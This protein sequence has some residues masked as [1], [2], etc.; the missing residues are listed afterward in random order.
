MSRKVARLQFIFIFAFLLIVLWKHP[1]SLAWEKNSDR[2]KHP[3]WQ[4]I[5][6]SNNKNSS[7]N[8][9]LPLPRI[10]PLPLSL[11]NWK[12]PDNQE[13]YFPQIKPT[14]NGYLIWS[15]FPVRVYLE[16]PPL[17]LANSAENLRQQQWIE[18]VRIAIAEWNQYL[19][20]QEIDNRE[21]ADIVVMPSTPVRKVKINPETGLYD[22]PRAITAQTTYQFYWQENK[23]LSHRMR[24]QV[25]PNLSKQ[26]TLAAIRHELGH[27]LGIWGHSPQPN[28]ALYFSQ[29]RDFPTISLRD[30]NTLKKIYQQPTRLGWLSPKKLET[31]LN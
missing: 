4:I 31:N 16:K 12:E 17:S 26:A 20:L 3:I 6:N 7:D 1:F 27:A 23:L 22:L 30:I 29:V 11:V 2:H 8:D 15:Q 9:L 19:P 25:S 5:V 13:N 28:D 18:A 24:I 14:P 21:L 10:H